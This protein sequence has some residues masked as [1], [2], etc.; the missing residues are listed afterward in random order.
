MPKDTINVRSFFRYISKCFW[1]SLAISSS[2]ARLHN[3]SDIIYS[4][5]EDHRILFYVKNLT[6]IVGLD[7]DVL[8]E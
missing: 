5:R 8:A 6:I 4:R 2:L 7:I 1:L 3:C